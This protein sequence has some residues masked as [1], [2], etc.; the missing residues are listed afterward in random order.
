MS[1]PLTNS[2]PVNW[3]SDNSQHYDLV[4]IGGGVNG[5]G[6]AADAASRGLRVLLCEQNDLASATSSKSS[7]LIHGGLRYLEHFQFSLVKKALT[8]REV[9]LKNAPHIIQPLRFVLPHQPHLR[10]A[11]LIRLG[12]FLYDHLAKRSALPDSQA[13]NF[14]SESPLKPK[15]TQGFIYADAWV[16]DARL[17]VLNALT[18]KQNGADILNY[19]RCTHVE[20]CA[21]VEKSTP[22][23]KSTPAEQTN[24]VDQSN[25]HWRI[26][27]TPQ[28]GEDFYVT[29][30]ALVNA[31]GPWV[32]SLFDLIDNYQSPRQIRLVKGSHIVVPKVHESDDAYILQNPDR[33]IVF[34]LPFEQEFSLIG[35]TDVEYTGSPSDATI[36]VQEVDYLINV[37]NQYFKRQL[38]RND[39]IH[40]F[41]GVRPLLDDEAE[42]AQNVSRD[43]TIEQNWHHNRLPLIS[44]FGGKITTYRKLAETV[45]DALAPRFP[46]MKPCTTQCTPLSGGDFS[47]RADLFNQLSACYQFIPKQV[48]SRYIRSYGTNTLVLLENIAA[49]SAMGEDFGHGLYQIEVDYLVNHEWARYAD[50]ILWRR[51]KLGLKFN[52]QQQ[53]RLAEYL[54]AKGG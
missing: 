37:S 49:L 53:H 17:V 5:A 4:I 13:I 34:V 22:E 21:P 16:D 30:D 24:H 11:C 23:E 29:C 36:S 31:A 51:S 32:S 19:C 45:V 2:P 28:T 42:Q 26:T 52:Q 35:T 27:L 6:V 12:L 38:T 39:I 15:F 50:D 7:K 20:Q 43:Y 44:A 47:N 8:E 10:P 1:N 14:N 40:T 25:G 18:A 33:R 46:L 3:Q 48:L 9:L 54:A 41:A